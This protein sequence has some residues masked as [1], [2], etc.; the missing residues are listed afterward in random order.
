MREGREYGKLTVVAVV[1]QNKHR[2][3]LVLCQCSCGKE[4]IIAEYHLKAGKTTSCGCVRAKQNRLLGLIHGEAKKSKEWRAWYNMKRRCIDK[5]RKD[6]KDYGGRGIATC[7][8]WLYSFT[9]FLT[10]MGR[11]PSPKHSID[12][13]DNN[14][15]YEKSNCRWATPKEQANNKRNNKKIQPCQ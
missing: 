4:K 10:D 13:K 8:D 6:Y 9:N 12:R 1:G 5:N 11:A 7:K 14:G 15:N 2:Q 3:T